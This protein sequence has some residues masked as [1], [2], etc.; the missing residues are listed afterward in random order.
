MSSERYPSGGER[1]RGLFLTLT[2]STLYILGFGMQFKLLEASRISTN[3][4]EQIYDEL[5]NSYGKIVV[6]GLVSIGEDLGAILFLFGLS[7]TLHAVNPNLDNILKSLK[8][9]MFSY[10]VTKELGQFAGL[11]SGTPSLIDLGIFVTALYI[12][13]RRSLSSITPTYPE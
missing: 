11:M 7:D 4:L 8:L 9:G 13:S 10:A 5:V 12:E 1:T 3:H 6:D 2:G